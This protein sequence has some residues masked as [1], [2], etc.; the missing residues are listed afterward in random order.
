MKKIYD[1]IIIGGG[2]AGYSAALYAQRAGMDALLIEK[3]YAGGQMTQTHQ[4]DNYPGFPDGIDGF[5]LAMNMEAQAKRF[6]IQSI[7]EEVLTVDLIQ[8]IKTVT[9][10]HQSYNTYAVMIATGAHPR[11]LNVENE[12]ELVGKGL[13]YCAACDG[14]FFRN[15]KVVVVGGGNTAIEDALLLSNIASH[16]T[17]IHRRDR[18]R[19][20]KVLVDELLKKDNVDIIW[21]AEVKELHANPTIKEIVVEHIKEDKKTIVPCNGVFVSIGRV[22]S[23]QLFIDQLQLDAQGYI[24][25][26]E[27]CKTSL[28]GV[29]AIGDVRSKP[30]RQ[31]VGAVSDGATAVH[32]AQTYLA[33]IKNK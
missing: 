13:A 15:Q 33:T 17:I 26:N 11:K 29:Y 32:E 1:V 25:A 10:S 19:G 8:P 4:I 12:N 9:T 22:P 18:F 14:A 7:N 16:V 21:N 31:I 2:P 27:D 3:S 24:L 23:S 30:L 6:G 28:A 20:E 5:T